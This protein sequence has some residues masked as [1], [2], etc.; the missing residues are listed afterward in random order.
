MSTS[1]ARVSLV[2]PLASLGFLSLCAVASC[3]QVLSY[4]DYH[5]RPTAVPDASIEDTAVAED[6]FVPE[7]VDSGPQPIRVPVRP[8]GAPT[9]SG[10]G[11]TLWLAVRVYYLGTVDPGDGS[12]EQAWQQRGYDIDHTCTFARESTENIG[13]C[14]RPPTADRDSLLDGIG[15]RD[16]NFGR[17]IGAMV[18]GAMPDAEK[19][20][21]ETVRA[22]TSTW[23]FRIDDVDA[24]KD[25]PYAPALLYRATDERIAMTAAPLKWDGTDERTILSDSVVGGDLNKANTIFAGGYIANHVWISGDPGAVKLSLPL[26]RDVF[27]T[28]NLQGSVFTLELE[29][30]HTTGHNGVVAGAVPGSDIDSILRPV[31]AAAGFCPGT[32]IYDNVLKT[33]LRSPDVSLG[34]PKMQDVTKVCDGISVGVGFEVTPIKPVTKLADPPPPRASKCDDAGM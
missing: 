17:H 15:C 5:A 12:D 19:I 7:V 6:T 27:T 13:T 34:A 25:D 9:P 33:G 22:G 2:A 20:L 28:L 23:I 18:R 16:N 10:K 29:P 24:E 11:K 21:N 1:P 4:D 3:A 14:L 8:A 31:A 30:T 32:A 26:T